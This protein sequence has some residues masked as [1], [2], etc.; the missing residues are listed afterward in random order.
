MIEIRL[1]VSMFFRKFPLAKASSL[2]GMS[3]ADM[4]PE[5]YFLYTPSGGRCLIEA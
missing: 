3:Q 4:E 5:T 1:G 2:E